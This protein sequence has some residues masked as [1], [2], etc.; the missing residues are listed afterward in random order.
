METESHHVGADTGAV[1][2]LVAV[3]ATRV[4]LGSFLLSPQDGNAVVTAVRALPAVEHGTAVSMV[5]VEGGGAQ[6]VRCTD[7]LRDATADDR[8]V[9]ISEQHV[10]AAYLHFALRLFTQ[11]VRADARH[12]VLALLCGG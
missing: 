12:K 10:R 5:V 6:C 7:P 4:E 1:V 11:V 3:A 8:L 9:A 2:V